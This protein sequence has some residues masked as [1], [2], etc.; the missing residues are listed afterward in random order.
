MARLPTTTA[1]E[2]QVTVVNGKPHFYDPPELKAARALLHDHL[3][4]HVPEKPFTG[5]LRLITKW[6]FPVSGKHIN[7]EYKTTKP[8]VTNLQKMLEDVMTD[9]HY[10][11]DD[12]L[13]TCAITEKFWADLPGL[14]IAIENL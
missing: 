1:Q 7:G 2:H 14:Y 10:W 8:D 3:A 11:P 12:S 6:C 9:L 4:G 13:I 5:P